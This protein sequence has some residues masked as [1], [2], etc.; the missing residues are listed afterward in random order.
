M[1]LAFVSNVAI[2]ANNSEGKPHLPL[3]LFIFIPSS[4]WSLILPA[5]ES[6]LDASPAL[7]FEK[8]N[9]W[10]GN[11]Q[12]EQKAS[13]SIEKTV[14]HWWYVL[15][16]QGE[17]CLFRFK[18]NLMQNQNIKPSNGATFKFTDVYMSVYYQQQ[19]FFVKERCNSVGPPANIEPPRHWPCLWWR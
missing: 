17:V 12:N 11:Y 10:M 3:T 18:Y 1:S 13:T 7:E 16:D 19:S 5:V 2:V 9:I 15:F 8:S 14:F 4:N 6:A